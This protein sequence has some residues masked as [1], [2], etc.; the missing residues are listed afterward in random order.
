MCI[1][2]DAFMTIQALGVIFLFWSVP[3]GKL[4]SSIIYLLVLFVFNTGYCWKHETGFVNLCAEP[5]WQ[6]G[7][8]II[9]WAHRKIS[10]T[11]S[12]MLI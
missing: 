3:V 6:L 5:V 10:V 2:Y 11:L 9:A 1:R 7:V 8:Y 4:T 12:R